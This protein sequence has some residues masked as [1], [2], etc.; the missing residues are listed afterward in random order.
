VNLV[1]GCWTCDEVN[2]DTEVFACFAECCVCC[3]WQDPMQ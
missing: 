3:F 1:V 2:L